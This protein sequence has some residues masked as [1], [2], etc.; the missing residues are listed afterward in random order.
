MSERPWFQVEIN[1]A[2]KD[3]AEAERLSEAALDAICGGDEVGLGL[4]PCSHDWVMCGP[5][6]IEP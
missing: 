6:E 2:A 3:L 1:F 5:K 4:H